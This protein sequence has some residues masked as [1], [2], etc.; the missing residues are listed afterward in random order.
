MSFQNKMHMNEENK[1]RIKSALQAKNIVEEVRTT[2]RSIV[3]D[4]L[5]T[6]DMKD[7]EL[8]FQ[9]KELVDNLDFA[10]DIQ[11]K[12][13]VESQYVP[14][15]RSDESW[16]LQV[17]AI[18]LDRL[19]GR[20][21]TKVM[22]LIG[23]LLC[24]IPVFSLIGAAVACYLMMPKHK[25]VHVSFKRNEVVVSTTEDELA[26]KVDMICDIIR[27]LASTNQFE[28][29]Y[30]GVLLWF[31]NTYCDTDN[32]EL[33]E[34]IR[35][36]LHN[37]Y[38]EFVD[39]APEFTDFFDVTQAVGLQ[40]LTTSKPAVRNEQTNEFVLRGHVVCPLEKGE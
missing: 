40:E 13:F 22:W 12:E 3:K 39:F 33:K 8:K 23:I 24:L 30:R 25:G 27:K 17:F 35:R 34:S 18:P 21:G 26:K 14:M 31:Q 28:G 16:F 4:Y 36:L 2:C 37:F 19:V 32:S 29:R 38:Y 10:V 6:I 11:L 20:L 15:K 5:E 1:K 9:L 7:R